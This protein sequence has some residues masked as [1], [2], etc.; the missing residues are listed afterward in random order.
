MRLPI[1]GSRGRKSIARSTS[2]RP[3]ENRCSRTSDE[4][5]PDVESLPPLA[6]TNG[7][8][9]PPLAS[10]LEPR[11]QKWNERPLS[12][13]HTGVQSGRKR[14]AREAPL[15]TFPEGVRNSISRVCNDQISGVQQR[16]VGP[17][18]ERESSSASNCESRNF[19]GTL[20]ATGPVSS[21]EPQIQLQQPAS[22]LL[23]PL[24]AQLFSSSSR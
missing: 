11:D 19:S 13:T 1:A 8:H 7:S 18:R 15:H 24:L 2:A 16:S 9:I 5:D 12:L 6:G 17:I 14:P 10:G 21:P 3:S 20:A 4:L 22:S 23:I